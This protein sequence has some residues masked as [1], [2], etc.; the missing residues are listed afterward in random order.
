[1][2]ADRFQP[3]H[4]M[5]IPIGRRIV[6]FAHHPLPGLAELGDDRE[7]VYAHSGNGKLMALLADPMI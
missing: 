5:L 2:I 3:F 7:T 4:L 1:M 6:P